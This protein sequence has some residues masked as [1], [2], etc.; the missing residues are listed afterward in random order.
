M[1]DGL[2]EE[3]RQMA[4][5]VA[6]FLPSALLGRLLWH[7]KMVKDGKCKFWSWELLWQ[8]PLAVFGA[9]V[10]GGLAAALGLDG[11]AANG[12]VGFVSWL[13]PYGIQYM[14][15]KLLERGGVQP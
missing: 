12:M 3:L 9:I 13:G 4:T 7:R 6:G 15:T 11:M 10:G 2:G 14:L 5:G 1:L 8:V